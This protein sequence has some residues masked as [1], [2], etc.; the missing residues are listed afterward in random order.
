MRR[1]CLAALLLALVHPVRAQQPIRVGVLTDMSGPS[2][3]MSGPGSV[4]AAQL[5]VE[6]AGGAVLGR[7]V[8]V[9]TGNHQLKPDIGSAI[10]RGWYDD[11]VDLI[12]DVP[13][14]AVGL[15]V[16]AVA[17]EKHRLFITTPTLTSDFTGKFCSPYTMQWVF[18]TTALANSTAQALVERGQKRWYF[19]TADYAFGH[20]M[21]ADATKVI[22]ANGGTVLGHVLHPFN[23]PDMTSF[24]VQAA[25]SDAQVI[26]LANGP[27]DNTNAIRQAAEFGATSK[28]K[29][30]ASFFMLLTDVHALGLQAAQGLMLTTG[31]Y[32][33]M[34]DRARAWSQRFFQR[35]G[36]M[37]T[38]VQAGTYSATLHWLRAVQAAGS[39]DP[40]AAGAKMRATPVDD[41]FARNGHLRPDGL[42]VHD[43]YLARVKTP[44]ESKKPW[45]Y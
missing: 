21:E 4:A 17:A 12:V 6:D 18:N 3:D 10:A 36:K 7:P 26:G 41:A 30:F 9:I 39:V 13:V 42:M 29:S 24:I 31:F 11:G 8:T 19:M 38:M 22:T 25:A 16:Q 37:P 33:D 23:A 44:A 2:M 35:T 28:G 5:A 1:L 45:D 40:L 34:D 43:L 20:S 15:A 32:W 27:P 14:S